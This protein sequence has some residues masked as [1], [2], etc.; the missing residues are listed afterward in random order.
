MDGADLPLA[1]ALAAKVGIVEDEMIIADS[2]RAMLLGM[3]YTVPEPCYDYNGAIIMLH[4]EQPDLVLLDINLAGSEQDGI[5]IARYIRSNLHMPYIFLTAN[6]DPG[7]VARAKEVTPNAFLVKPF[8]QEDLYSA[9]EIAMHNFYS[10]GHRPVVTGNN[11]YM[12]IKE[13]TVLHKVPQGDIRYLTSNHVYV[14]VYTAKRKYLVRTSLQEYL[15][16]LDPQVFIRIHRSYVVNRHKIE[17]I[18]ASHVHLGDTALPVSKKYRDALLA[19][20]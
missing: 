7:T 13:G 6:S 8:L 20:L 1:S 19:Q 2:I 9:I 10:A 3:N 17:T 14:G 4:T 12:L 15:G 5:A 18:T 11:E 16:Q